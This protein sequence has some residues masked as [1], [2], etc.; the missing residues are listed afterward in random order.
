MILAQ[1]AEDLGVRI[2]DAA[3]LEFLDTLSD[4]VVGRDQ[5][6]VLLKDAT[7]GRFGQ[8]QLFEQL[9][10]ELLAQHMRMMAGSGLFAMSP[11]LAWDAFNRLNRAVKAELLPLPVE[12]FKSK[13]TAQPTEERR[14]RLCMKRASRG[15]RRPIFRIRGSNAAAKSPS[16][17]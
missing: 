12:D 11:G 9:R 10:T 4:D 8:A 13:V 5:F 6:G 2:S 17:T 15:M 14:F 16:S 1:K 3:I 7:N